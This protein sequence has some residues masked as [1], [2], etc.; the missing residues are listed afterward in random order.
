MRLKG[1]A[2]NG[3]PQCSCVYVM[4]CVYENS[5]QVPVQ[6]NLTLVMPPRSNHAHVLVT[7]QHRLIPFVP[8][9]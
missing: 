9:L 2:V 7:R 4:M 8:F 3:I 6:L 5:Y 1:F